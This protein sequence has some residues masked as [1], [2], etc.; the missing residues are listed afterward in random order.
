MKEINN[1]KKNSSIVKLLVIISISIS[2]LFIGV[3]LRKN[4][5]FADSGYDF[6]Y[7]GGGSSYSDDY[8]YS[9]S[10]YS[11]SDSDSYSHSN[12]HRS[13]SNKASPFSIFLS[14]SM[15]VVIIL[16]ALESQKHRT[17]TVAP[18]TFK[19]NV[20][21]DDIVNKVKTIIPDFNKEEFIK[22]GYQI[23]LDV[24]DAWMNFK[25]EDVRDKISDE[26]FNMYQSQLNTME[27]K[28][29]QNIMRG[30]TKQAAYLKDVVKQNEN[31]T[32]T[33]TY[34][35]DFYDYIVD[36][37]TGRVLRGSA[38]IK[39][40]VIYEMKFRKTLDATKAI[41]HCPNCGAKIENINGAGVC[42]YCGSKVVSE[43]SRWI[44][45]DKKITGQTKA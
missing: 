17:T 9:S 12:Y 30:F 1:R 2:V 33:A 16:I 32:I 31:I 19:S 41:D 13:S 26:M 35:I 39:M 3:T 7:D 8:S 44:L 20:N 6:S 25:L 27:V 42:E 14:V 21:D 36:K 15:V 45:T 5:V 4:V 22:E 18:A 11:Y 38:G 23:Y 24:Q 40:R 28:G 37:N 10:D 34:V 43:N 29:E